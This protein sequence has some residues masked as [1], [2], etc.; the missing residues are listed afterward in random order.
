[1]SLYDLAWPML[2]PSG[3][4]WGHVEPMFGQEHRRIWVKGVQWVDVGTYLRALPSCTVYFCFYSPNSVLLKVATTSVR[5]P[6][7]CWMVC[8]HFRGLPT[9]LPT[10]LPA[11]LPPCF[12]VLDG[13][14]TV[15][16]LC[17]PCLTACLPASSLSPFLFTFVGWC[18]CLPAS[19]PACLPASSSLSLSCFPL[20]Q[21]VSFCIFS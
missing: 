20:R 1:M 7:W 17:H 6:P 4:C 21:V 10:C 11:C 19:P 15:P 9:C 2:G 18:A 13:V 12:P 14:S 8:P 16:R 3:P 5:C